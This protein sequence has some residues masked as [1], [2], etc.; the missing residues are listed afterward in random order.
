M[1]ERP[2]LFSAPMV[3]ALIAGTK[4]QTRRV[5]KLPM[6]RGTRDSAGWR[7]FDLSLDDDR[8]CAA[9][10]SPYGVEGDRLWCKE[11]W[12]VADASEGDIAYRADGG[13]RRYLGTLS[14]DEDDHPW[15]ERWRR[16]SI[17][18]DGNRTAWCPS[19]YMPR[20]ISRVTLGVTSVRVER[21]Q[22]ITEDDAKAEGCSGFDP[23]PTAEGGT[24]YARKGISSAPS[25][26]AHFRSLW[27][28]INGP[29]SWEANPWVWALGFRR[30]N[31]GER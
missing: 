31:G 7:P 14:P 15:W 26:L 18:K 9:D 11:T 12:R 19:I 25:P 3:R 20:A 17:S 28:S 5:V 8:R 24:I 10:F 30:I 2:I 22:D 16:H 13:V 6:K 1:K 4:T 23:E 27:K 21:L 29:D